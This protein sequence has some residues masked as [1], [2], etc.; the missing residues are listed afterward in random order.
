MIVAD[1]ADVMRCLSHNSI[2]SVDDDD[3][4]TVSPLV[5]A[6]AAAAAAVVVVVRLECLCGFTYTQQCTGNVQHVLSHREIRG[7][8]RILHCGATEADRQGGQ[9]WG[10]GVPSPTD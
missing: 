5:A 4:L 10:E 2:N 3:E 7:I 1:E 6:A 8:A 9:D